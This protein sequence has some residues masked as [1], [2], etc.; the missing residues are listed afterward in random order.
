VGCGTG[1]FTIP[2][3]HLVGNEGRVHALDIHPLAIKEVSK[4]IQGARLENVSLTKADAANT[5]LSSNSLDLI[6][7]FGVIPSPT[8]PLNQILP[9][10]YRLLK[11]NGTMAVWTVFHFLLVRSLTKCGLFTYVGKKSGVYNFRKAKSG[12]V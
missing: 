6:L 11:K 4:K 2:A 9:E 8:L 10:M 3:A 7:L 1:F 5:E 12:E